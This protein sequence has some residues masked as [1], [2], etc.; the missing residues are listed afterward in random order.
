MRTIRINRLNLEELDQP[1][2][3]APESEIESTAEDIS[4]D[5][6]GDVAQ[7]EA[8]EARFLVLEDLFNSWSA[9]GKLTPVVL[10]QV[11]ESLPELKITHGK[12]TH[13]ERYSLA[14]EGI[15]SKILDSIKKLFSDN[16]KSQPAD[17]FI[18]LDKKKSAEY[19]RC[20][21]EVQGIVKRLGID[22]RK[23]SPYKDDSYGGFVR[24]ALWCAPFFTVMAKAIDYLPEYVSTTKDYLHSLGTWVSS[25]QSDTAPKYDTT[26]LREFI[27]AVENANE[28][29][30]RNAGRSE[31]SYPKNDLSALCSMLDKYAIDDLPD[32]EKQL[33]DISN[34]IEECSNKANGVRNENHKKTAIS[35]LHQQ[36]AFLQKL[37]SSFA[38]IVKY[39]KF[40]TAA[41]E[42]WL[43][44]A[45]M[46][47]LYN[48]DD[49]N[50]DEWGPKYRAEY[51]R[52]QQIRKEY[53]ALWYRK[54][55]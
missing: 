45:I 50:E 7:S 24:M 25:G 28:F 12:R 17:N 1:S 2:S 44:A 29:S 21:L 22:K 55:K 39:Q 51:D 15:A 49:V 54:K 14:M 13:E 33:L 4:A 3:D 47:D 32:L 18:L 34:V 8:L 9:A 5:M 35:A 36:L 43:E 37:V 23:D 30:K 16:E 40:T 46:V 38:H 6:D 27:Q 42:F 20:L 53:H 48:G 52:I 19:I 26:R 41:G 31:I 10:R 11:N